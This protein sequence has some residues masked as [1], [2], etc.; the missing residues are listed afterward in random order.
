M[1]PVEIQFQRQLYLSDIGD[2]LRVAAFG[3]GTGQTGEDD[4]GQDGDDGNDNEEL[5]QS[6][7][8]ICEVSFFH[9]GII[10]DAAR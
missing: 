9:S 3:L 2:S 4:A 7:S 6:E 8:A 10:A 1:T 5:D